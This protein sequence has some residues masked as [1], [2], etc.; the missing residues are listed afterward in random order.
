MCAKIRTLATVSDAATPWEVASRDVAYRA[1]LEGIV[2]L[3]ND[4]TLPIAPGKVALYGAGG[5]MTIKGGTGS[6]E[7][8]ERHAVTIEEGLEMGGFKVTSKAWLRAYEQMVK[9]GEAEYIRTFRKRLTKWNITTIINIMNT[10]YSPP[11]GQPVSA[12]DVK[13]SHT[14]TCIYVVSRQAGEGADR[15]LS[16]N[17]YHLTDEEREAIAFC[18]GSYEKM[19]LVINVGGVFDMS[20]LEQIEGINAVVFYAQQGSMGG[21][22]LADLL[23]GKH[24][25]SGKLTD[26]WA[27][28]YEDYPC[29][30][31]YSY[32]NGNLDQE[33]YKEGI[34]VGYRYFDTFGVEPRYPFGYGLSY[35]DFDMTL[36]QAK[37]E[38]G[39]VTLQ[40]QVTNT[41]SRYAG[42]EV[43]QVYASCP[44]SKAL[45][46][47]Y[48]RLVA[49]AKTDLLQ[50]GDSQ[51]LTLTFGPEALAS[52][53][54]ADAVTVLER[55]DYVL[56]LG[57]SSRW[58][59]PCAS[60]RVE[61]E[62][63][64]SRHEH[65]CLPQT[66]V[67][68]LTPPPVELEPLEEGLPRLSLRAVDIPT[69][70]FAY[71]NP[72]ARIT[73]DIEKYFEKLSVED[74]IQL[75]IGGGM[76]GKRFFDAPG[77]AGST[78]AKLL[79]KKIPNVMLADGP[80]GL[81]L[82][83]RTV[84]L[85]SG[86]LKAVEPGMHLMHYLP[87][88]VKK[89]MLADPSQGQVLY[90]YATSF[91]V[92]LALA[93]SW[94]VKVLEEV[95]EAVAA[96]MRAYGVTYWL[97]PALNIHRNPLCGRNFEYY[98]EDPL[99][100]GLCAAAVTKGVQREP[101]Y[102]V[103]IKHF[104]CNN[105][106]DNRNRTSANVNERA[107]R[108]I[109]LRGFGIVVQDA[110]PGAVMSSYNKL[111]G[112]YTPNSYDLLT[113]VL[114][115]EWGYQGFV[116][117]DWFSTGKGLGDNALCLKAGN[118]LIMP[119]TPACAP[120]IR[121]ALKAGTITQLDLRRCA[122]NVLR[123]IEQSAVIRQYRRE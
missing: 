2:L 11:V 35:T 54:T 115:N 47:E 65:V 13:N 105:Q 12:E 123:A 60:I 83:R 53:R 107:L 91:P 69:R 20:F 31:D 86:K 32:L 66:S 117:T 58:N 25:P 41:G 40:V 51:T 33:Y 23:S 21:L 95:G 5:C 94:N 68:E 57:N 80:A 18:A 36:K 103:T 49:Y 45:P 14:D 79:G 81:R 111:N 1:A 96:E 34:Y 108:E 67:V 19:I 43:V 46:K 120:D 113:K 7:V 22:A 52:Y 56:R 100:S 97:A 102:F 122:A 71:H 10:P 121:K 84:R 64:L 93:Q 109:Y 98:S 85:K 110:Q 63:I 29:A 78:T 15:K 112:V 90:Q 48:Q 92:E 42:R 39:Q 82:Q 118:D 104:A 87:S 72:D 3:E 70:T 24:T 106:E 44:Q 76:V 38:D 74:Q 30:M 26:T 62:I 99:I 6:G 116:M 4:G 28:R 119:G 61:K 17:S 75:T 55:G 27:K 89:F 9:E 77:S 59:T 37:T 16:D 8:N 114:R 73:P 88:F 101:G 50:C